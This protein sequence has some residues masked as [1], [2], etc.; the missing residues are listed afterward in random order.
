MPILKNTS[1]EVFP[2]DGRGDFNAMMQEGV[3]ALTNML[4]THLQ[5]ESGPDE[6][7]QVERGLK[8][9]LR[10]GNGP[11]ELFEALESENFEEIDGDEQV[12]SSQNSCKS[13]QLPKTSQVQEESENN[14]PNMEQDS[15]KVLDVVNAGSSAGHRHEQDMHMHK[16]A[17]P[18][19]D[20]KDQIIFDTGE[21]ELLSFPEELSD[22]LKKMVASSLAQH[23]PH[24]KQPNIDFDFDVDVDVDMDMAGCRA[25]E[26]ALS[27]S[28]SASRS[29]SHSHPHSHPH[30]HSHSHSHSRCC[31]GN[32]ESF[33]YPRGARS[34]PDFSQLINNDKP[35]CIFC[36]YYV[37]FGEPPKNMI[38]WFDRVRG[39][40]AASTHSPQHTQR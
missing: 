37:V 27:Q 26:P 32:R 4:T 22:N 36:E 11:Q 25:D 23:A 20:G 5:E 33:Q 6:N 19:E 21:H 18:V 31:H 3:K 35:M 8:Q 1:A 30:S 39:Q 24:G 9:G 15:E 28:S 38:R 12:R 10:D 34:A 14:E 13:H 29:H 7:F 16:M 17:Q 40:S 2:G